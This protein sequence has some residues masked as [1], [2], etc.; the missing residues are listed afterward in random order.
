[1]IRCYGGL[2]KIAS[3]TRELFLDVP[4]LRDP[5]DSGRRCGLQLTAASGSLP[6][7]V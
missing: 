7:H 5:I 2:P 6:A 1:M 4:F 3:S